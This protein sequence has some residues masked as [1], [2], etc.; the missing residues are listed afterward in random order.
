MQPISGGMNR[1]ASIPLALGSGAPSRRFGAAFGSVLHVVG[2]IW[3]F[4]GW[5]LTVACSSPHTL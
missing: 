2:F 4:S 3:F 1:L 5:W